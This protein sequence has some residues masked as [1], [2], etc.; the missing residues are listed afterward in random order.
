MTGQELFAEHAK[1]WATIH[2]GGV[3]LAVAVRIGKSQILADI[4]LGEVPDTIESFADLHDHVDANRYGD[5]FEWPDRPEGT[6]VEDAYLEAHAKFWNTVQDRL[7]GWIK[8]GDMK[9]ALAKS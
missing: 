4:E 5:A 2:G 9:A 7:D 6:E 8:R 3:A 1:I